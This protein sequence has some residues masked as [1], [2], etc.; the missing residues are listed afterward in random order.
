M[1][2]LVDENV[3]CS[4]CSKVFINEEYDDHF[5][6]PQTKVCKIIKFSSYNITKDEQGNEI[7]DIWTL[8]G[9][10]YLFQEIPEDKEH[11]KIPFEPSNRDLT[12]EKNNHRPNTSLEQY[13]Y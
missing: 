12:G 11:T 6:H 9:T 7:V 2:L 5:C 10:N 8:D 13:L 4:R 3:K 1:K